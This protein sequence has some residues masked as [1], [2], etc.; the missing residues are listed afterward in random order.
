MKTF[1]SYF[2][3]KC[4]KGYKQV[5]MKKKGK[6]QVPN[7]VKEE[8]QVLKIDEP[9]HIDGVGEVLAKVDTGNEAY[10][11]LHGV[12]VQ[13]DGSTVTFTTAGDKRVTRPKTDTIKIHIGSGVK[14][15]RPVITLDITVNGKHFKMVPF[16]VAD[17]SENEEP[18]LIGAPFL[19]MMN[20]VVDTRE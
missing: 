2:I 5:G 20:A 14:E 3:E 12:D 6:R 16:S 19:K 7:C 13:D 8:A 17:R 9:I 18:V 1:K 11:V 15:D 4:W 10:N